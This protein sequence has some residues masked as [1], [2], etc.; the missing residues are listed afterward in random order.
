MPVQSR[1]IRLEES[2]ALAGALQALK[3]NSS[4]TNLSLARNSI[5]D[6]GGEALGEALKTNS[7][8]VTLQR[9][10]GTGEALKINSSLAILILADDLIGD[11]GALALSEALETNWTLAFLEM[12]NNLIGDNGA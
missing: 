9:S 12:Q 8:L 10:S 6:T 11:H 4:V 5:R 2:E 3:T 7:T 1:K